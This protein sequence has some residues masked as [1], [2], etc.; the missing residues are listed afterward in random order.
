[1]HASER[2]ELALHK[3]QELAEED[4]RLE[5]EAQEAFA[6]QKVAMN[7]RRASEGYGFR[8]CQSKEEKLLR[9]SCWPQPANAE[10]V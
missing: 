8:S 10:V 1:V 6:N 7:T 4:A 3:A 9:Q 2:S 5:S